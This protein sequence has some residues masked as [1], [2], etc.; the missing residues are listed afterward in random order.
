MAASNLGLLA[1][2]KWNAG[3]FFSYSIKNMFF[4][5]NGNLKLKNMSDLPLKH[6]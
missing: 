4:Y 1:Q 3:N 5:R 6:T 2:I